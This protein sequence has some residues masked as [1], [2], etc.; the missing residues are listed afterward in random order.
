MHARY[1]WKLEEDVRCPETGVTN[2]CKTPESCWD[3]NPARA[4][5]TIHN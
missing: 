4:S 3:S 5:N 1:P 2:G